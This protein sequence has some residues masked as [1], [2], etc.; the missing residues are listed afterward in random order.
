MAVNLSP[1]GGAASQFFDDN[2]DPLSGGKILTYVAG[3]TTPQTTYT[4]FTGSTPHTNPIILDAAGRVPGGEIWLTDGV[5]YKFIIKTLTD[6]QIGSYDNIVAVPAVP[7]LSASA[8]TYTPPFTG[9]AATNVQAKL[10]QTVSVKD[11]GAVGDGVVDDTAAIVNAFAVSSNVYFPA[12]LYNIASSTILDINNK[13]FVGDGYVAS[14]IYLTGNAS[15]TLKGNKNIFQNLG[16]NTQNT[17][18]TTP[19]LLGDG[20][21]SFWDSSFTACRFL[22]KSSNNTQVVTTLTNAFINTFTGCIFQ[23][24]GTVLKFSTEANRNAFVGCSIRANQTAANDVLIDHTD[25][26]DNSFLA[27]DIETCTRLMNVSGGIVFFKDCYFEAC[28]RSPD[29]GYNV[30]AVF[31]GGYV[32]FNECYISEMIFSAWSGVQLKMVGNYIKRSGAVY[33][34]VFREANIP[35]LHAESNIMTPATGYFI[36]VASPSIIRFAANGTTYANGT[37]SNYCRVQQERCRDVNTASDIIFA[38]NNIDYQGNLNTEE[39]RVGSSS[40]GRLNTKTLSA[41]NATWDAYP[42]ILGSYY[43]WVDT[44][45]R[46]RIKNGAPTSDTDGT[47]VGTQT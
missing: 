31:T 18:S 47:V 15:L 24:G 30:S 21:S 10:A 2:G 13:T 6:V 17:T 14:Q 38:L 32:S 35:W 37:I 44:S 12:G 46:L 19:I 16:F 11:F 7:S 41:F 4:S 26:K 39:F 29:N 33:F 40:A 8:I 34:L 9:G 23:F 25:G 3:T 27:C 20:A 22:G 5:Q 36:Q 42:I 28:T 45:G 43:L 1:I